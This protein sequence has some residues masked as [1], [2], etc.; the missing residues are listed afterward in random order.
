MKL[1]L[2]LE[3]RP[4]DNGTWT[5]ITPSGTEHT[6]GQSDNGKFYT[7]CEAGEVYN[8]DSLE[9]VLLYLWGLII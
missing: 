3:L 1:E 7:K 9:D 2:K 4:L 6:I 5:V 8:F